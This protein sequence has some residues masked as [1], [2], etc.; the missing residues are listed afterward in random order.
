VEKVYMCGGDW[1]SRSVRVSMGE[2]ADFPA[3][4]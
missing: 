2:G 4:A 3:T 1:G